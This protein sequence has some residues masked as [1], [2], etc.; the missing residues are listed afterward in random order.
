MWHLQFGQTWGKVVVWWRNKVLLCRGEEEA[1]RGEVLPIKD[2]RL[3][4]QSKV[5]SEKYLNVW[6]PLASCHCT[7]KVV[8]KGQWIRLEDR[9]VPAATPRV[10]EESVPES[11]LVLQKVEGGQVCAGLPLSAAPRL[12]T[13]WSRARRQARRRAHAAPAA[14]AA[15][16]STL[17]WS[18]RWLWAAPSWVNGVIE[19]LPNIS[20]TGAEFTVLLDACQLRRR[21]QEVIHRVLCSVALDC[22]FFSFI[23]IITCT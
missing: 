5:F 23:G 8:L 22:M 15:S 12:V 16:R 21:F 19:E 3:R 2:V 14:H 13:R 11:D 1:E 6:S 10:G 17:H 20:L 4:K 7:V 9:S 18:H